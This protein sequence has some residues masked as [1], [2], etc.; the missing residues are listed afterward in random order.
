[1]VG[2]IGQTAAKG[3]RADFFKTYRMQVWDFQTVRKSSEF[4]KSEATNPRQQFLLPSLYH[5]RMAWKHQAV[6]IPAAK[7]LSPISLFRL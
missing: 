6:Q 1:M 4:L 2:G 7:L 3:T 5:V